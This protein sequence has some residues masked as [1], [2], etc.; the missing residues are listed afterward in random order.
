[1]P[2]Q[3]RWPPT[4]KRRFSSAQTTTSRMSVSRQ[5]Y[6]KSGPSL[7]RNRPSGVS[8]SRSVWDDA[9]E[10]GV[11]L[12]FFSTSGLQM[13]SAKN[14]YGCPVVTLLGG[15]PVFYHDNEL[16]YEVEVK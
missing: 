14:D 10:R 3:S 9:P 7:R 13:S 4:A 15:Q 11:R 12:V 5:R 6:D 16:Q 8:W 1:M 2:S